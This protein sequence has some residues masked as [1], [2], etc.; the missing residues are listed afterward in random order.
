VSFNAGPPIQNARYAALKKEHD[1]LRSERDRLQNAARARARLAEHVSER[2]TKVAT[3]FAIGRLLFE[4]LRD[5]PDCVR[6]YSGPLVDLV[7]K[8]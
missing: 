4:H 8:A 5:N 2:D 1:E 6:Y 7:A 3:Y